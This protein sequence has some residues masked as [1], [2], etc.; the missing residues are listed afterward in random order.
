[1][2]GSGNS[3]MF[4]VRSRHFQI[5]FRLRRWSSRNRLTLLLQTTDDLQGANLDL[6]HFAMDFANL[7]LIPV[8]LVKLTPWIFRQPLICRRPADGKHR[9]SCTNGIILLSFIFFLLVSSPL[10]GL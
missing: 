7:S 6:K 5:T 9:P 2:R 10:S 3:E 8:T 1:M 4:V